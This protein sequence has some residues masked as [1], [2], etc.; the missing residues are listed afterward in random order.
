MALPK[1]VL[2]PQA[3]L[4]Q[5]KMVKSFTLATL[6]VSPVVIAAIPLAWSSCGTNLECSTL[7]VPLDYAPSSTSNANASIALV[8]YNSTV[9]SSQRLGS[10]LVNPGGPGASGL[11]FVNAGAG[12]AISTLTGGLYD[13][14]GWD[15]RG[16]VRF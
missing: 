14:I 7:V 16:Y 15:P 11:S 12:A 6:F 8:R 3:L 13:I 4:G 1:V 5:I 10:L 2:S 9:S